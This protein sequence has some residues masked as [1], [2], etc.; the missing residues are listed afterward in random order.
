M[1]SETF[2]LLLLDREE[3]TARDLRP[4]LE[5]VE[6]RAYRLERSL[7]F[8]I[9]LDPAVYDACI[10]NVPP[11]HLADWVERARPIPVIALVAT[12][13]DGREALRAGAADYWQRDRLTS[14]LL[15]R[16]LRL[17]IDCARSHLHLQR[18]NERL[19]AIFDY[20]PVMVSIHDK[21]GSKI[22]VNR[23]WERTIGW[24]L[25]ELDRVDFLA[26]CYPDPDDRQHVLEMMQARSPQWH[27]LKTRVRD[28]RILDTSWFNVE[29]SDGTRI[30]IGQD[31]TDRKRTEQRLR[32]REEQFRA[33]FNQAAV[34]LAHIALTGEWILVNDRLCKL[35]GYP[36]QEL[37]QKNWCELTHPDDLKADEANLERLI[38]GD[39][40]NYSMEKRYIRKDGSI[41][42]AQITISLLRQP[43][44][45]PKYLIGVAQDISDRKQIEAGIEA[46]AGRLLTV[47]DTVGE[48]IT[49]SDRRGIFGIFNRQ[50]QQITGYTAAEA[51]ACED[52]LA[53]LYP[54]PDEYNR[55]RDRLDRV[56]TTGSVQNLET[57]IR[58]KDGS[59]KTLLVS[60]SLVEFQH[61]QCFLSAYRDITERRWEQQR[62]QQREQ[63]L[64]LF[65]S[66]S[67]HGFF[68]MM[69]DEPIAWHDGIDKDAALEDAFAR[70]HLTKV[71]DAM[72][73]QYGARR[74]TFL[75]FTP[76]DFWA[77]DL[78][79][80]KALLRQLFDRGRLHTET[81]QYKLDGTP[82]WVEG[83]YM[84]FYDNLGRITGHFGVQRNITDRKRAEA[85]LAQ[86]KANLDEAQKVA[87]VGSWEVDLTRQTLKWSAETFRIFG[88]D[89][90]SPAPTIA[91]HIAQIH[92]DDRDRWAT[93]IRQGFAEKRPYQFEMRIVRP[94]GEIRHVFVNGNPI[95]DTEGN[96]IRIF[97]TVLDISDRKQIEE[98]LRRSKLFIETIADTSP[99]LLYLYDMTTR[100]NTYV[101][102][103]IIEI[104][105][106]TPEQVQQAGAQFFYDV[107][108]P[109]DKYLLDEIEARAQSAA[110][111]EILE[112][113]YRMRHRNG[114]WRWLRSR[115]I[116]FARTDD[117]QP[118]QLLGTAS[119]ITANKLV[120]FQLR[121]SESR[122]NT[123]ISNTSDGILIVDRQ[124]VIRFAN[125]AAARL[126][127][128]PLTEL[129]DREFGLPA[130]AGQTTELDVI[131]ASGRV[132]AGE[133]NVSTAEWQG[134]SVY[135]ISLR[136]ITERR[137]AEEALRESEERFRQMAD[138]IQDLFWLV[139][140]DTEE[141]PAKILYVSP[142][143]ESIWGRSRESVYA[144]PNSW[145]DA[146]H[147]DDR[148]RVVPAVDAQRTGEQTLREYRILRPDGTIRWVSDRAFP[149]ID[150]RGEVLR[151]AGITEDIT[152]RKQTEQALQHQL[153][154]ALLLQR[155]TEEIRRSLDVGHI[156]QTA[157]IQMG[158]AFGVN[159]CVIHTYIEDPIPQI[160][161]VA[162]YVEPGF[163]SM[164][165]IAIPVQGN[166]HAQ[167]LLNQDSA[168]ASDNVYADPLFAP[169]LPIVQE[170]GIKSML[171]IA[172]S[173]QGQPNGIISLHQYDRYRHWH[174]D[175]I[176]LFEAA[177]AQVGIALAQARLLEREKQRREELSFK[178]I[179]LEQAKQAADAANRAKSQ[180]LAN[181]THEL[182]TPLNGILG[183]TQL[184]A[185]SSQ[186]TSQ[187][188][189][190]LE[191]IGRSGEHLLSL[192]NDILDL[193]KIE[194]GQISV[195]NENFDL[196]Q[197]LDNLQVM[198][199]LKATAKGLPLHFD[200]APDLPQFICSDLKKLRSTLINLLG[201]AIKFTNEG[202]VRLRVWS[203]CATKANC[204]LYFSVEDTGPGIDPGELDRLFEAFV[205]T[206]TGQKAAEGTGLGLAIARH[207]V[208][209]LGGDIT[210][211]STPGCGS[212]FRFDIRCSAISPE[213]AA[214]SSRFAQEA[215]VLE[216]DCSGYR[217]LVVEDRASN[218]QLA[219]T[220]LES[221]GFQ[222]AEAANGRE[223]LER[224]RSWKPDLILM[225][226]Y[227]GEMDGYEATQ[228]IRGVNGSEA[229]PVIIALT[230]SPIAFQENFTQPVGFDDWV[231]KP[232]REN[233]LLEKIATHLGIDYS[234]KPL[235]PNDRV[236]TPEHRQNLTPADLEIMPPEWRSQLHM[237]ALCARAKRIEDLLEQIPP[238]RQSI[239]QSLRRRLER[240]DFDGLA[241]LVSESLPDSEGD[242]A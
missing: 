19:Q 151:V 60:T 50:M 143:Y 158:Q 171:G 10:V 41:V 66:Q 141:E 1:E 148:D 115:N 186:I 209:L 222:V 231:F 201:N 91:E 29:L 128:R 104:L 8:D 198:L 6:D 199:Q 69:L 238:E 170:L 86:E 185:R 11:A 55:A 125:P 80:G 140:P 131:R 116:V 5:Q 202:T 225:D 57:N 25:A 147:S 160:P 96:A 124:G 173:Y 101:N 144:D 58:A 37:L 234:H 164:R 241:D 142:A 28:G 154:K 181:M 204:Q 100:R 168:I 157:A 217:I 153:Q 193:S 22:A 2:C 174:E 113:E 78:D 130:I 237:A 63:Q 45:E 94:D 146:I 44:G 135:V 14:D 187:Q 218:R 176:E 179:A 17:T 216:S 7:D 208:R 236:S 112:T 195:D 84:C 214:N 13:T 73:E 189:E 129:V 93:S 212:V 33:T 149:I 64:E 155:I 26:E 183:F 227:M 54:D 107:L 110:D 190:Y 72:V 205:Q 31:I 194:A 43:N 24:S 123:V 76:N 210:V 47:I 197:L 213:A 145:L 65:F 53:R 81:E 229:T 71:N 35:L 4:L 230:A 240:L 165:A 223:G 98:E 192:I 207:F 162:E 200:L 117:G 42:W 224:W 178:N 99:Q 109:E 232:F 79:R 32:D 88:L 120:E 114:S 82:I 77:H 34:G 102:R 226:L 18:Q 122:L 15:D 118:E 184:M 215:I 161:L 206:T 138:N 239:A 48:G 108:H 166:P 233:I 87:R 121:E 27:D 106:Y 167:A 90:A 156:F 180:F 188:Q 191:I 152:D 95:F 133:M 36:K 74:E 177:A 56:L 182:R 12:A 169:V 49:L 61:Q 51:N 211:E 39:I 52:F 172:T 46:L 83:D 92:P 62:L 137:E 221:Y 103:Q 67:L 40:E 21:D 68:F 163:D 134:E 159:R 242:L 3:A 220:L 127:D 150:E 16:S 89:P 75:G 139:A 70:L 196:Y 59:N 111:G 228:R 38:A 175:E 20:L 203:D 219:V 119:D 105:G 126:F 30:G 9:P 132:G 85:A 235:Y 23:Q 136:D 97:G